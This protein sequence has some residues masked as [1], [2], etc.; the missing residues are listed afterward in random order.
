MTLKWTWDAS[1]CIVPDDD[2]SDC[3]EPT[4]ARWMCRTHYQ[5]ARRSSDMSG[6]NGP[7]AVKLTMHAPALLARQVAE[8]ARRGG[9]S[10]SSWMR[11]VIAARIGEST[12]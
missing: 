8:A 2:G 5:R 1:R 7:D 12:E 3:T 4:V 11:D 10:A 9:V 6:R